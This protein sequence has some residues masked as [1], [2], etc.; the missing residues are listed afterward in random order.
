MLGRVGAKSTYALPALG[1]E[2]EAPWLDRAALL[3][4]ATALLGAGAAAAFLAGPTAAALPDGDLAY[5]RLLIGAELLAAD[6]QDQALASGRLATSVAATVKQM[7]ADE[8]AHYTG[9]ARLVTAAGQIP[10]TADD[11]DFSYRAKTF[12]SQAAI[13]QVAWRIETLT[14]GAYLGAVENVQNSQLRLPIG[15][16]GA[17][18]AQHVSALAQSLGR[19]LIG[20]SFAP[21]LSIDDVSAALDAYES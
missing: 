16:I 9:L 13:L 7:H 1:G 12:A 21:S 18:E 8:G 11:I 19:P 10:A 2:A 6:F 4:K 20:R 14:L 15:Q 5:L 17:N 3:R